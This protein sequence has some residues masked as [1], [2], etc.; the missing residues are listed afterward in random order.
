MLLQNLRCPT[1]SADATEMGGHSQTFARGNQRFAF[2]WC[3][4]VQNALQVAFGHCWPLES[5]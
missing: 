3:Q 1:L 5:L 4:A 2:A